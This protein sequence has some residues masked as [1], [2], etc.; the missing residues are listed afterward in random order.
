MSLDE[1]EELP[2]QHDAVLTEYRITAPFGGTVIEK[3]ITLG[4]TVTAEASVF[5]IADLSSVWIDLAVYQND[6]GNV[7][8]GQPCG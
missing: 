3:H 6:I 5:T 8:A 2:E 4:E 7:R 1:V